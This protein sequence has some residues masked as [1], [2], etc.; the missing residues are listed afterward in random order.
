ME[1]PRAQV[2]SHI[3]WTHLTRHSRWSLAAEF[4]KPLNISRLG[5]TE[6]GLPCGHA[7]S[8]VSVP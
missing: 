6:G 5:M 2:F 8:R 7:W 1:K 4:C 3:R